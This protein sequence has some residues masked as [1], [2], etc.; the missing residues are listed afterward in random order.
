MILD[1]QKSTPS[2]ILGHSIAREITLEE[3]EAV[4]G[5]SVQ[6]GTAVGHR[7]GSPTTYDQQADQS[8]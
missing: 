6:T 8:N 4:S 3:M 2:R 1:Q 7:D 5:G